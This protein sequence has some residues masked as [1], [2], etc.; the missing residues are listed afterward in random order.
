MRTTIRLEDHLL[1]EAKAHAARAGCSLNEFIEEAV[2]VALLSGGHRSTH[3]AAAAA[4]AVPRWARVACRGRPRQQRRTA[5]TDGRRRLVIA[6]DVNVLVY[7]ARDD[8]PRHAAFRHWLE[9]SL[10]APEPGRNF[11]A[12]IVRRGAGADEPPR[13]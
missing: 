10:A 6:P 13:L 5:R 9:S 11:R 3:T 2:R 8:A 1:R 12:G 7:A 4:A